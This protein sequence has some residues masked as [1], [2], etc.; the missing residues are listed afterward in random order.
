MLTNKVAIVT[1]ATS[2]IGQ[3]TAKL[4][5][6]NGAKVAAVGRNESELDR[7]S[8]GNKGDGG[9]ITSKPADLSDVS[10]VETLVSDVVNEFGRID[11][12]VN[13][14]GIIGNG[15]IENTTLEQWDNM[16]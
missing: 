12:L 7:L 15:S 5:A 2:G 11:I 4:F 10:Q 13:A 3:A 6:A 1:G 9:S 14:A 8:N 16:L